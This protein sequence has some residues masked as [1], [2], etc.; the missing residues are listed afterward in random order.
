MIFDPLE[1]Q[2]LREVAR[3]QSAELNERLKE[4]FISLRLTDAA[5]DYAVSQSYDHLYGARPLRR[6][7]E[8]SIITPLSRMIVGGELPEDSIVTAD[9]GSSGLVFSVARDENAAASRDGANAT[10]SAKKIR[11]AGLMDENGDGEDD[12]EL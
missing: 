10:T 6:W 8:R 2:Q 5:L 9:A 1:R 4:R 12:M 3:L 11:L 7:L